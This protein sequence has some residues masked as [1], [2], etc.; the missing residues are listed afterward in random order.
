MTPTPA[1]RRVTC[2]AKAL[3]D[4]TRYVISPLPPKVTASF[5]APT[6]KR[7]A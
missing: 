1:R 2:F 6:K 5:S 4:S 3:D 7:P